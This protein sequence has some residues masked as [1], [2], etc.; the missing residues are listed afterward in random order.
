MIVF[1]AGVLI[2]HV[3][4]SDA[5]HDAATGFMEEYEEFDF[6]ASMLTV[7][8]CLVHAAEAGRVTTL[9]STFERLHLL[10][11]DLTRPDA[12]GI[13]EI[14]AA[15]RLRMPDAVALHAAESRGVG[16][17]TTD[18]RLARAAEDRGVTAHLLIAS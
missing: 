5:F 3:N 13:A 14:R 17:V 12:V 2:G 10:Q 7:T 4:P 16:L 8:E 1:D 6:G 18:Q 11:F 15:T 9:L